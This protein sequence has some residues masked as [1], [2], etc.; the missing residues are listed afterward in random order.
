MRTVYVLSL[1][2]LSGRWRLLAL[3][4]L[5]ALPVVVAHLMLRSP[6]APSV[7][8]FEQLVFSTLLGG[9]IAPLVVLAIAIAAFEHER[10]D[11]TLANL[12]L[13]PLPRWQIVLRKLFAVLTIST[14]FV[15]VSTALTSHVAFM[16]DARATLAATT[17]AILS[18]LLY[19]AA[20]LWLGLVSAQAIGLGLL[21]IV[22]WEG[23]SPG[24]WPVSGC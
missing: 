5:A 8:D 17:A 15:A 24:T 10:E 23:S 7:A 20:F 4:V 3:A 12:T 19:S 6:N 21:Y 13:T 14:P 2:Q 9:A 1:R 18:V 22:L 16:G 11:R